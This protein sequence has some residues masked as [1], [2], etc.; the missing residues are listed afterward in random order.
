MNWWER[1]KKKADARKNEYGKLSGSRREKYTAGG[2]T[3]GEWNRCY[4]L[5]KED[6]GCG[7]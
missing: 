7:L 5:G 3:V 1:H 2:A 6:G 4:G